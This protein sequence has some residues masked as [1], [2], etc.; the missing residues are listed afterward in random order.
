MKRILLLVAIVVIGLQS[1]AQPDPLR[2]KLDSIFQ[3]IDKAQVP[4]GYLKEYGAELMPIHCFNGLLTD[5]NAV[6]DIDAFRATYTDISTSKKQ[7]QLEAM[8]NLTVINTQISS[9]VNDAATPIALLYG[10]YASMRNDALSQNLFT[11]SNQRIFDVAGRSQSPYTTNTLFAAASIKKEFTNT[12]IFTYNP[13]LYYTNT[14]ITINTL[15]VDFKDGQGY[16]I[17]PISGTVSK[18]YTDSSSTK[19]IDFKV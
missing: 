15:W 12:V 18:T 4:T 8:T 17:I 14:N 9:F 2:L 5:S 19:L 10:N 6:A 7:V 3:F 1:I 11:V 16:K 13:S